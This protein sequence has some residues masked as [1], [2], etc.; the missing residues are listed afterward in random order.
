[1]VDSWTAD[2]VTVSLVNLDQSAGKS[3][4]VQGG[5]YAE[6]QLLSVSD[7]KA[8]TPVN[9]PCVPLRLAP[10]AG[11]RLTIRMK[12]FA[13]DPTLAFPWDATVADLGDA[14]NIPPYQH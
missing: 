8:T 14:P 5:A 11:A 10:G 6:H 2:S 13:N 1:L 9:A 3:V 12:R 7:G 4:I